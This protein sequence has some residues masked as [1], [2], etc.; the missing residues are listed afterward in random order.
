MPDRKGRHGEPGGRTANRPRSCRSASCQ[1]SR[2][3]RTGSSE[4][5]LR[6]PERRHRVAPLDGPDLDRVDEEPVV[7]KLTH[8]QA[9]VLSDWLYE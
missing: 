4:L 2:H 6:S 3:V 8:D 9:F 5:V 1:V 7:I